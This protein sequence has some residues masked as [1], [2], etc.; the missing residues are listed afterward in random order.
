[1]KLK[2]T[3]LMEAIL[4]I[5]LV[6]FTFAPAYSYNNDNEARTME[7]GPHRAINYYAIQSFLNN[8]IND[9]ILKNMIL[10]VEV[11]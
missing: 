8:C 10:L 11:A 3:F 2:R 9:P 5:I 1:M 7:G 6:I 4:S